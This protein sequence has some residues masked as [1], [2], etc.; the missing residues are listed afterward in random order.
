[1]ASGA[2][3]EVVKLNIVMTYPVTWSEY[4]VVSNYV[5]NFYDALGKYDFISG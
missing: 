3:K 5:Q 1:M 2:E 4:S